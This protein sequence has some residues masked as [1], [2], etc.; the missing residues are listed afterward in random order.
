MLSEL[1]GLSNFYGSNPEYLLAGGGNTSLKE[2]GVL[3]VKASGFRLSDI[4]ERGF[5]ALDMARL[6]EITA[7][8][9]SSDEKMAEAEVL[10]DMMAS[11][12][13]G[14][15]GRPSVEALLHALFPQK[16]VVHLHP[17]IVNG[18]T[19]SN[20]G[21][22]AFD[23]VFGD[24][25]VWLDELKPGYTLAMASLRAMAKY[26]AENGRDLSLLV[27]QNHGI[28]FAADS[29]E[30]I[31]ALISGVF[32][33][34]EKEIK[35]RPDMSEAVTDRGFAAALAPAVR[36]L[37]CPKGASEFFTAASLSES[38]R[39]MPDGVCAFTPDHIVYC[40]HKFCAVQKAND[41]EEQYRLLEQA[42]KAYREENGAAP[43]IVCVDGLGAFACG[44]G[45][46]E[47]GTAK[48]LFLDAVK[49]FIYAKSFGGP[50]RMAD[51]MI[52][53]IRS[54]E[55]E[56]Y[57]KSVSASGKA[58]KR[59]SGKITVI[60]GGAQ[61]FGAGLA[62]AVCA[63]GASVIIADIN[64][65]GAADFASELNAEYGEGTA[66]AVACDVSN[67]ESVKALCETA[68]LKRGGIDVFISN[69]GILRSGGLEDMDYTTFEL[70]T[71][72]NYC[73]FF[74]CSKYASRA[75]KIAHR[76]LPD[77]YFDIIQI[78]SK[79]GLTGSNKNFAYAGGKFGG[80]GL[81]QSFALEL[82]PFNIKVNAICPGNFLDGP[83]WTDPEKGLFVQYLRAGKVPGA[84]T[85]EDVRRYYEAKVPMKRGC[86]VG[87][88]AKALFYAIEQEY[89]TGQAIPVTG[90]QNMLK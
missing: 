67:E 46:R 2:S 52:S 13:P 38:V 28:F 57:R 74:L 35:S 56:S 5:V 84:K 80:I 31:K 10:S 68:C 22:K 17:A 82:V 27:M 7:K 79:S 61:G 63:E 69:A 64:E 6:K 29:A 81:V 47:A 72:V 86:E 36:A 70:M 60:T 78:N 37:V 26:R 14:Q 66:D 1:V 55:V 41:I 23:R 85:V 18:L 87:D 19:C 25:A 24:T 43:K 34:L 39:G 53:F 71:K 76:F 32:S 15:T 33:K 83:L 88:V 89:E 77:A 59:L 49:I 4:D 16:Y 42:I 75:M 62:R 73:A 44:A 9:Y 65:R 50:K 58:V 20:D 3:Y 48:A 40:G 12:L 21:K 30:Q 51:D 8:T 90:G 11:R 54:W 45:V